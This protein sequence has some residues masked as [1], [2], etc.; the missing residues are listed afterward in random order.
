MC[1]FSL[2]INAKYVGVIVV[3]ADIKFQHF[4]PRTDMHRALILVRIL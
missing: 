3:E 4:T 2:L 1:A